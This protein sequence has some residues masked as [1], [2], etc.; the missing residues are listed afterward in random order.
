MTFTGYLA[1]RD[2]VCTAYL[3]GELSPDSVPKL[4]GL[5]EQAAREPLSRL[6]LSMAGVLAVS[7]AAVRCLA[8]AQQRMSPDMEIVVVGANDAVRLALRHGG[9]DGALL[10]AQHAA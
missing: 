7:P 4:R 5:L 1:T 2:R 3:G 10:V 8:D 9:L 6:V